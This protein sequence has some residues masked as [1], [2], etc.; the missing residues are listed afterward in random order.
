MNPRKLA[1]YYGFTDKEVEEIC[2]K[3]NLDFNETKRWYDGYVMNGI[4]MYNPNSIKELVSSNQFMSYWGN[5]ASYQS[6]SDL[7]AMNYQGLKDD[8]I[9]LLDGSR[10]SNIQTSRFNNDFS[11][12]N[13]KDDAITYLLH[14]GYLAYNDGNIYVPNE[15]VRQNLRD[16]VETSHITEYIELINKSQILLEKTYECDGDFVAEQIR[17]YHSRYSSIIKYNSEESLS[18][19]VQNAYLACI[20]NYYKPIR[21]MPSGEGVAD[22]TYIPKRTVNYDIPALIIELKWNKSAK[23]AIDQIKE[24]RYIQSLEDFRGTVLL[25]GISYDKK[26]KEHS[27]IIEEFSKN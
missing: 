4:H 19:T 3:N 21:E 11:S 25:V 1:P 12:I 20:D 17:E 24:K 18:N 23:T 16:A 5:T 15:E 22:I 9:D 26:T 7:I 10:I 14:L 13:S 27:C 8:L 2:K 6:V